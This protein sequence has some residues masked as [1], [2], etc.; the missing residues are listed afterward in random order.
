MS[1][2]KKARRT[3][4]E[5]TR[6]VLAADDPAE[7]YRQLL[8]ERQPFYREVANFRARTDDRTPQ[9]VVGDILGF[10]ETVCS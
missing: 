6:P 1:P 7:H 9:Q 3:A 8:E 5:S 10:L 4:R 2:Q